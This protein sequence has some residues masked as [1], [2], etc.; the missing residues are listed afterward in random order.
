MVITKEKIA[1]SYPLH[2]MVWDNL[3]DELEKKLS[4][5]EQ[6]KVS[7]SKTSILLPEVAVAVIYDLLCLT[8]HLYF[9]LQADE[10][11][12]LDPR[13]RTPLLLAVVLGRMECAIALL[14]R[15]ANAQFEHKTNW[16]GN[17]DFSIMF[18]NDKSPV[19]KRND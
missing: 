8:H 11:D 12:K 9:L 7:P 15:G 13:G 19:V 1:G 10:L 2:L 17:F 16:T 5:G 6:I 4:S 18:T 3:H 14:K